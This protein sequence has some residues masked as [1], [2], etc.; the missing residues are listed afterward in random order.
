MAL[1]LWTRLFLITSSA[2]DVVQKK[3]LDCP[4]ASKW[5]YIQLKYFFVVLISSET[6]KLL[7]VLGF[8][9]FFL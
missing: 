2:F 9:S 8:K 4:K 3:N 1:M 5:Q 6:P 7:I